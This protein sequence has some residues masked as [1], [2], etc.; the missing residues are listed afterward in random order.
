MLRAWQPDNTFCAELHFVFA[1]D[2]GVCYYSTVEANASA[3]FRFLLENCASL[4]M[5]F[6]RVPLLLTPSSDKVWSEPQMSD[7]LEFELV[8]ID[9]EA[10]SG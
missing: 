1:K 7:E 10:T 3:S 5:S 8:P 4:Q 9:T 2:N 6:A